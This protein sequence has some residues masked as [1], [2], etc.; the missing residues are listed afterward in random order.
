MTSHL[1]LIAS[2]KQGKLGEVLRDLKS[3]TAKKLYNLI[4]EN[5]KES[6][7][8]WLKYMFGFFGKPHKQDYQFWVHSNH[9]TEIYSGKVYEQKEDYIHMNPVVAGFVDE[10]QHWK[11]SSANPNGPLLIAGL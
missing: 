5:P 9:P 1:H 2:V 10:P 4:I 11:N 3:F 8:E 6:R 7:K